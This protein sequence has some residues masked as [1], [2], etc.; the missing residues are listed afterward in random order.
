MTDVRSF[1]SSPSKLLRVRNGFRLRRVDTSATPGYKGTKEEGAATLAAYGERLAT[2]QEKLF[3]ASRFGNR[4]SLLLVL[5][6]MDTAG[7]G[8][9]VRHVVGLVDPQSITHH[10]FKQPTAEERQHDFLWRI[11]KEVPAHGMIGAFDRSH[12]EDVLVH[13]VH[14]LSTRKE[15]ERRY[16]AINNF[17]RLLAESGTRIIKVMLHISKDE[18]RRRLRERLERPEKHWKY[19]PADVTERAF[20]DDYQQAYQVALERTNT[21]VAPW[22]VVP[23]DNKWYARIAVQQLMIDALE[24][25][26]LRWPKA[27]FDV[28]AEKKLLDES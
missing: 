23:A 2:L 16:T 25:L 28:E 19:S 5:Q 26:D 22:F 24:E 21:G 4:D 7:K 11:E 6:G 9:I 1:E 8:G 10:A 12:Y 15:I 18:Q 14:A 17:E 27:D 3:A 20:W 13:R